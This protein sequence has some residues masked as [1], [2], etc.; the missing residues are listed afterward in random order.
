MIKPTLFSPKNCRSGYENW[1]YSAEI[2]RIS[3]TFIVLQSGTADG[4][5]GRFHESGETLGAA[6]SETRCVFLNPHS[7]I[8]HFNRGMKT[9]RSRCH[10]SIMSQ[11][12]ARK[13]LLH[14]ELSVES[15]GPSVLLAIDTCH[16][17]FCREERIVGPGRRA[18][19]QEGGV[20]HSVPVPQD[21]QATK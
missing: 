9:S 14:Q 20:N 7:I 8:A 19:S 4:S 16:A 10:D 11:F 18:S 5:V 15:L 6:R 3:R 13:V 1:I 2:L 21:A 12:C 17:R